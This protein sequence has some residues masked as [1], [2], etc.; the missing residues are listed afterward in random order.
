MK[1]S[2][3][4]WPSPL[5]GAATAT[6][7]VSAV[8][9]TLG[10]LTVLLR[11]LEG[12]DVDL[13]VGVLAGTAL[14]LA[15]LPGDEEECDS[16]VVAQVAERSGG[17]PLF[18]EEMVNRIL[19]EGG[20][21]GEALPETV[22]AVL[23][24]RLD[25][26]TPPERTLIQHAAVIGQTFW[27]G[28]IEVA[29]APGANVDELL[30]SLAEKDLVVS[31]AGSR[32]AG[33]REFAFK[34]VLIRDVAYATLPKTVRARKHAEVA[35]FIEERSPDRGEAVIAMVADHLGHAAAIGEDSGL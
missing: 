23:A 31:S 25:A 5:A 32:L 9:A 13:A 8:L 11:P 17:N 34:H 26:L 18:A 19:E 16:R 20:Q 14:V 1:I 6:R 4:I 22:H 15:L 33:E 28:A 29:T 30:G 12:A 24:A 21:P 2:P 27:Q 35:T 3:G 10:L 7:R